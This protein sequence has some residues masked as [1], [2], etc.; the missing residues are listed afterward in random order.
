VQQRLHP[1]GKLLHRHRLPRRDQRHGDLQHRA[2][3]RHHVQDRLPPLRERVLRQHVDRFLRRRVLGLFR[4][5]GRQRQL[6]QWR[7]R[8]WLPD[9]LHPVQQ[10]VHPR[11]RAMQWRLPDRDAQ[12]QRAVL[13]QQQSQLLWSHQLH[14]VHRARQCHG[15][16][17][18]DGKLWDPVQQR[19]SPLQRRVH[20]LGQLL[21]QQ[22]LFR[23]QLPQRDLLPRRSDQL[24]RKL[25]RPADELERLRRLRH[26][27][28]PDVHPG[29]LRRL[30]RHPR[31]LGR[32]PR[33][34]LLC[35]R[36]KDRRLPEILPEPPALPA[37]H[38]LRR[39]ILHLQRQLPG[40]L[41]S[42]PVTGARVR[43]R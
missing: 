12:L 8:G 42:G 41:S 27:L 22:R 39:P 6:H 35:L 18:L 30:Q 1:V 37:K 34:G 19:L 13:V 7:L 16:L 24:Q 40:A 32:L 28:Q 25:R 2:Y 26:G 3:L 29:Y 31:Q 23:R 4:T 5:L 43:V 38:H 33:N 20:P 14:T 21:R 15:D 9:R 11:R 17:Q 10:P 36:G